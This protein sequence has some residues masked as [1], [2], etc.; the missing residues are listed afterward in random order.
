MRVLRAISQ[1]LACVQSPRSPQEISQSPS[2]IFLLE[3]KKCL[4]F[5]S[6][7]LEKMISSPSLVPSRP[8][9]FRM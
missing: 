1:R 2:P 9:R 8:R 5:R 6:K 3:V 7:I 4:I